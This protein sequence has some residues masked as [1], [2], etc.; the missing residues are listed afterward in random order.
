MRGALLALFVGEVLVAGAHGKAIGVAH[1][2]GCDDGDRHAEV[3][4]HAAD[5]GELLEVLFA[6]HCDVG[7][8]DV[9]ELRDYGG[10]AF[11]VSGTELA[12]EDAREAGYVDASRPLASRWGRSRQRR[13]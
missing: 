8:D 5:D 12:V 2:G 4:H 7:L 13:A 1:G 3:G 9:E 6:E 10:H 11:E